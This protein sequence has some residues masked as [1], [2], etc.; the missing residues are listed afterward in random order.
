[1]TAPYILRP[2]R[3]V[4]RR[5]ETRQGTDLGAIR[6]VARRRYLPVTPAGEALPVQTTIAK[7]V[8]KLA[9]ARDASASSVVPYDP[10][11]HILLR[12]QAHKRRIHTKEE[13]NRYL[14]A[15]RA[16]EYMPGE[17]TRMRV[18]R[19]RVPKWPGV[20]RSPLALIFSIGGEG[21]GGPFGDVPWRG[22]HYAVE[23]DFW[24]KRATF[25]IARR[26][27]PDVDM[28]DRLA[29]MWQ[30]PIFEPGRHVPARAWCKANGVDIVE[31]YRGVVDALD[32]EQPGH[33]MIEETVN[34]YLLEEKAKGSYSPTRRC[35]VRKHL[36]EF[37]ARLLGG[38]RSTI[39]S[40]PDWPGWDYGAMPDAEWE[41]TR[42]SLP[43][44]VTVTTPAERTP[45]PDTNY[46]AEGAVFYESGVVVKALKRAL[47]RDVRLFTG[48]TTDRT[49]AGI[50]RDA[51][52]EFLK[53]DPT[54]KRT[55]VR[56]VGGGQFDCDDF[57]VMMRAALSRHG[58]NSCGIIAGDG[59]AWVFFVIAGEGG[60][61]I[62]FVEPQ[63]DARIEWLEGAYSIERRCEVML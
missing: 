56:D 49:I 44:P 55:Y 39:P 31:F 21:D 59:H 26:M 33:G 58:M 51:L 25:R 12:D 32:R 62:E 15:V 48:Q 29:Y 10:D 45:E 35:I 13:F 53:R 38:R 34:P 14:A 3:G 24:T 17:P 37:E 30:S 63:T 20:P 22:V 5:V 27:V 6:R 50:G 7:A 19:V 23:R 1:M 11:R 40:I 57:A 41:A 36:G 42:A 54:S 8:A 28:P 61:E 46:I 47:G 16:E 43:E 9:A 18:F 60:P 4:E 52:V 2:R